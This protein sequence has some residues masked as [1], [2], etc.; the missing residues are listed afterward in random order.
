MDIEFLLSLL[1]TPGIKPKSI[2]GLLSVASSACRL[3]DTS[4]SEAA[5][6]VS[7]PSRLPDIPAKAREKAAQILRLADAAGISMMHLG[8]GKYPERLKAVDYPPLVIYAKGNLSCLNPPQ[9]VTIVGTR[10]PTDFGAA[11][12]KSIASLFAECGFALISGLALGCDTAA[13][14]GCLAAGGRTAAILAHGLDM[15]HPPSNRELAE[16][17]VE[18]G[19]CLVSEHPPGVRPRPRFFVMRNR[20]QAAL[21]DAVVVIET[22]L[23]GGTIHTVAACSREGKPLFCLK[24][25][26]R[27]DSHPKIQGN[28]KY[29][30]QSEA[31]P[32]ASESDVERA[33]D[34]LKPKRRA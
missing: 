23:A 31:L 12:A 27:Y 3:P 24:H 28:K 25:P 33:I 21:G 30:R 32:L 13:H 5:M 16:E 18:T 4:A 1:N 2:R 7:R 9:A 22:G 19:G 8:D 10:Q 34:L 20:L 6:E 26:T 15:V 11:R 29:L 14:C 17:I